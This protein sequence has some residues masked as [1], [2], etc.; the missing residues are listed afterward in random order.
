[1]PIYRRSTTDDFK[2][3]PDPRGIDLGAADSSKMLGQQ[4]SHLDELP[5]R[6]QFKIVIVVASLYIL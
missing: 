6:D 4:L 1:M 2:L 5:P 3:F